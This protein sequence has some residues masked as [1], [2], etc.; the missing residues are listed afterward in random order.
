MKFNRLELIARIEGII[1]NETAR[2]AR[3]NE[4]ERHRLERQKRAYMAET[5]SAWANFADNIHLALS[6]SRP[7]TKDDVPREIRSYREVNLF[8]PHA[9]DIWDVDAR[10]RLWRNAKNVL[11]A[12]TDEYVTSASL[13]DSGIR[14]FGALIGGN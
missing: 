1:D 5:E 14:N 2:V 10:T 12:S 13:K 4:E 7:V 11:E 8:T 9:P 6:E 3:H